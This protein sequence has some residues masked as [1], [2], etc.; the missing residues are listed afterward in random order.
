MRIQER[1]N[2]M[3]A[4]ATGFSGPE[5]LK[6]FSRHDVNV[7]SYPQSGAPSR[8]VMFEDCLT[9][10]DRAAQLKILTEL[11]DYD[12]VMKYGSPPPKDIE[13][14][15]GWLLDQSDLRGTSALSS[16]S[17][18]PPRPAPTAAQFL[19]VEDPAW[20]VFISHASEDKTD[21]ARPLAEALL[22]RGLRVWF[23]EFTLSVGDSL[24]RSI[25]KGLSRSRYGVVIISP[26]F[27]SKEWPQR[28]LDG[29]VAKEV[30]GVKVILPVWHKIDATTLS[31]YSPTLADKLA[32]SSSKSL[33]H[34][35][36]DLLE[37][38]CFEKG[39]RDDLSERI[40]NYKGLDS[41]GA[42]PVATS[43][44]PR[45]ATSP[46]VPDTHVPS[47]ALTKVF[48][49]I[50]PPPSPDS[51]EAFDEFHE[52]QFQLESIG[53]HTEEINEPKNPNIAP[54]IEYSSLAAPAV[55]QLREQVLPIVRK[56]RVV[57]HGP[58]IDVLIRKRSC[59]DTESHETSPRIWLHL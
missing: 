13:F 49:A 42:R 12:A 33:D 11:L 40:E 58:P 21:F 51:K 48:V 29:L 31:R 27:L 22:H 37:A 28:E 26:A 34:V 14:I 39:L 1:L 4:G 2:S 59:Y 52:I 41:L 35:V 44:S 8:K 30:A 9:R 36:R 25:D 46:S 3:Y 18:T 15:R 32:T 38:M 7:E 57:E 45:Q 53:V 6:F 55:A 5:I 20:D 54:L 56:Y 50:N 43:V 16:P 47:L 17:A 23:D 24:R 10:F 19:S